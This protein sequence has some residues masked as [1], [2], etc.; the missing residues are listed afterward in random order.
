MRPV[1]KKASST[2]SPPSVDAKSSRSEE[3]KGDGE[4]KIEAEKGRQRREIESGVEDGGEEEEDE[5]ED[6]EESFLVKPENLFF[7]ASRA[8]NAG[9]D[10][11]RHK[12]D[13]ISR[14][15]VSGEGLFSLRDVNVR[16]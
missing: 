9:T 6:E 11:T 8:D 1:D 4:Q 7:A 5:E 10:T 12:E 3:Y 15:S 13:S 16:S 14:E 2:R